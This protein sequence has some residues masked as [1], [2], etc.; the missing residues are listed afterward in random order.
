[1]LYSLRKRGNFEFNTNS[2]INNGQLIV[3]RRPNPKFERDATDF[4]ACHICYGMYLRT[5]SRQHKCQRKLVKGERSAI[6]L[7]R[8]VEGRIHVKA[9]AILQK[10]LSRT[11]EDEI[12]NL[13]KFDWLLIELGNEMSEAYDYHKHHKLVRSRLR[14]LGRMLMQLKRIQPEVT[15]FASLYDPKHCDSVIEAIRAV[16]EFRTADRL[17]KY[18]YNATKTVTEVKRVAKILNDHCIENHNKALKEQVNDF[19]SLFSSRA[20]NRINKLAMNTIIKMK[21]MKNDVLPTDDDIQKFSRFLDEKRKECFESLKVCPMDESCVDKWIALSEITMVSLILFCRRRVGEMENTDVSDFL[22]RKRT[23]NSKDQRFQALSKKGKER[24][25]RYSRML[26]RGK[27]NHTVPILLQTD[28]EKCLELIM[29]YRNAAGVASDNN[30]LFALPS[31]ADSLTPRYIG[32]CHIVKK[33]SELCGAENPETLRGT[34]FRKHFANFCAN[35]RVDDNTITDVAK[36]MGHSVLIHKNTYRGNELNREIGRMSELLEGA[37][38][39]QVTGDVDD[40]DIDDGVFDGDTE[41]NDPTP[42]MDVEETQVNIAFVGSEISSKRK[43]KR[44]AEDGFI[45]SEYKLE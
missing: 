26:I 1:M 33:F 28:E 22:Q 36:F 13:I 15:D 29:S 11:K 37:V 17:F 14:L 24:V 3:I 16:A 9:S 45:P 31:A 39:S 30:L 18:P 12:S 44:E 6:Y 35:E 20:V 8:M 21:R 34:K 19:L 27:L 43:R 23:E 40:G 7:S 10:I 25:S 38:G 2:T 5:C 32:G 4:I 41:N 42:F